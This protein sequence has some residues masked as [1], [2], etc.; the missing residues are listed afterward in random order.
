MCLEFGYNG[1]N[2]LVDTAFEVHRVGTRSHIL[3]TYID[4]GLGKDSGCGST[5]TGLLVGLGSDFLHHLGT[6]VGE[7][8]LKLDFLSYS[9]TVLCHLRCTEFLVYN[10]IA[11][12]GTE[13]DLDC[14]CKCICAFLHLGAGVDIEF[15]IFCHNIFLLIIKVLR[16]CQTVS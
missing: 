7:L 5:V 11:A 4:D 3:Q 15:Y 1:C 12:F 8:V 16:K 9:D 13:C 6:H 2:C 14:I 10:D